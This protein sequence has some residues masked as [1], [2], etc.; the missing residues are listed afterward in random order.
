MTTL[1]LT[2]PVMHL[3]R[4]SSLWI[5]IERHIKVI[6]FKAS[7]ANGPI[8]ALS[9]SICRDIYLDWSES[10]ESSF[11]FLSQCEL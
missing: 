4:A 7:A 3:D 1:D 2:F 6:F 11:S 9:L 8:K 5:D 10:A